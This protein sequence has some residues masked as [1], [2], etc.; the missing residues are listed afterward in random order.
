MEAWSG[1]VQ[2]PPEPPGQCGSELQERIR[3]LYKRKQDYGYD[4]NSVIQNKK[5]FRNPSIYEKLIQFCD[6]DEMGTNFPKELYDGHLFGKESYYDELAK[7]QAA[8]ME[9]R[10]KAAKSAKS[11][12]T[13]VPVVKSSQQPIKSEAQKPRRSKWDQGGAPMVLPKV[14]S[15][16]RPTKPNLPLPNVPAPQVVSASAASAQSSASGKAISA[17]GPLKK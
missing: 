17:F 15:S 10:E 6:I 1:G 14:G 3:I 8:D 2:L 4:M 11:V 12:A 9:R 5:A 7:V 13:S 16:G